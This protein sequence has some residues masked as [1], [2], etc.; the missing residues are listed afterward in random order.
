MNEHDAPRRHAGNMNMHTQRGSTTA[1]LSCKERHGLAHSIAM[2]P[3]NTIRQTCYADGASAPNHNMTHALDSAPLVHPKRRDIAPSMAVHPTHIDAGG[4]QI[5]SWT[6][7]SDVGGRPR[8]RT[9]AASS[10]RKSKWHTANYLRDSAAGRRAWS[11]GLFVV[12]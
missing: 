3:Y 8:C 6:P 9:D 2:L 10:G 4:Q 12:G 5:S 11:N 7:R 1:K